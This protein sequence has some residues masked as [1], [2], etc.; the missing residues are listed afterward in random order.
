MC[1]FKWYNERYSSQNVNGHISTSL[2][3]FTQYIGKYKPPTYALNVDEVKDNSENK[4]LIEEFTLN[5]MNNLPCGFDRLDDVIKLYDRILNNPE[6]S[7]FKVPA[8][9]KKRY[10]RLLNMII[11]YKN[12]NVEFKLDFLTENWNIVKDL[13]VRWLQDFPSNILLINWYKD[14]LL[15]LC[16]SL[17][18]NK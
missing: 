4:V 13:F 2:E 7:T 6:V 11:I 9:F 10:H 5:D 12:S 14:W 15:F 17:Y 16:L 1:R 18:M 3:S 8:K